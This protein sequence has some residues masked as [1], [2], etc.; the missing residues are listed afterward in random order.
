MKNIKTAIGYVK[1]E[2]YKTYKRLLSE[3]MKDKRQWKTYLKC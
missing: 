1:K 3:I 2:K